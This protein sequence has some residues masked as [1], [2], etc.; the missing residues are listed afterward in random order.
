[1]NAGVLGTGLRLAGVC[2]EKFEINQ[3][4]FY[5]VLVC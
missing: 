5:D 2:V 1:M 4:L 3:L